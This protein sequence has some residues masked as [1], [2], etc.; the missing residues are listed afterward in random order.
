MW[1]W[2]NQVT[3]SAH[4]VDYLT[5]HMNQSLF[6][7]NLFLTSHSH[8]RGSCLLKSPRMCLCKALSLPGHSLERA[9]CSSPLRLQLGSG[10]GG[11]P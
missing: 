10:R 4:L 3:L 7:D 9:M 2:R 6:S 8:K 11:W 5:W 1:T